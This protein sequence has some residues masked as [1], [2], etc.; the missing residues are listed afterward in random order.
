VRKLIRVL[1]AL[2]GI[3]VVGIALSFPVHAAIIPIISGD[4][5][6]TCEQGPGLI[7]GESC[8]VQIL[9]ADD[10][11]TSENPYGSGA[12]WISYANT[13]PPGTDFA[14]AG[15]GTNNPDGKAV[16]A[17]FQ[18]Q[19]FMAAG[20]LLSLT[21]WADNTVQVTING[22]VLIEP[23]Y[24]TSGNFACA[25]TPVAFDWARM[26]TLLYEATDAGVHTLRFGVFQFVGNMNTAGNPF[27]L[28]YAGQLT[29]SVPEPATIAVFGLGLVG[30]AVTRQRRT[31]R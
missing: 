8:T 2:V 24:V 27:G 10:D 25:S 14:P 23:C 16:I 22:V 17:Y 6:E 30:L 1:T 21:V 15:Y 3:A 7:A 20:D 19:F 11:W 26:G 4:G 5:T 28:L 13:S 18:E 9:T 12:R 29:T 31:T